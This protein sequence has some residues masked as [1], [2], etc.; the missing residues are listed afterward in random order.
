MIRFV[1]DILDVKNIIGMQRVQPDPAYPAGELVL[2]SVEHYFYYIPYY[3]G[4]LTYSGI[5]QTD[6]VIG[7][8][9]PDTYSGQADFISS[10]KP[11]SDFIF[12]GDIVQLDLVDSGNNISFVAVNNTLYQLDIQND[13]QTLDLRNA[14]NIQSIGT[15]PFG[16]TT[17]YA[18]ANNAMQ[19]GVCTTIINNSPDGGILWIDHTQAYAAA[20]IAAA[21]SHGW[22]V[23]YE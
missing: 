6:H 21:I 17:L 5:D 1:K 19:R 12:R 4:Y 23:Y 14:D 11:D 15:Q 20:V 2:R 13:V 9:I 8:S 18:I 10:V 3:T 16:V 22:H 7:G